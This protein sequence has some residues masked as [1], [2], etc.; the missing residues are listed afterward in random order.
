MKRLAWLLLGGL[1]LVGACRQRT[2]REQAGAPGESGMAM[3][4]MPSMTMLPAMQAHLDSLS[5]LPPQR[6]IEMMAAH[7]S[8]ARHML[9][10]MDRDMMGMNMTWDSAGVALSGSVKRDLDELRGLSGET[11][12]LRMRAHAGRMRR[13]LEMHERMMKMM[14]E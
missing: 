3:M 13:L 6:M 8:L 12:I 10:L 9:G 7:D 11:L 2:E 1:V 4:E 14:Q 5:R